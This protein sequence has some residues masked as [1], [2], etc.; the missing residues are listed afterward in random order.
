MQMA[1]DR[2]FIET[3]DVPS[4]RGKKREAASEIPQSRNQTVIDYVPS[5]P[6]GQSPVVPTTAGNRAERI[7]GE[8]LK[9]RITKASKSPDKYQLNNNLM[10]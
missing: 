1:G 8:V 6:N 5:E 2:K 7:K 4:S 10:V 9:S 3:A